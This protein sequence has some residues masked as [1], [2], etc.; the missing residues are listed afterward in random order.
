MYLKK[1][2]AV[3]P[4]AE[5]G[6]P[7]LFDYRPED[8]G[9]DAPDQVRV[10]EHH[11]IT[12]DPGQAPIR[13]DIFLAE[14]LK[15]VTRSRIKSAALAGFIRVNNEA[16]KSSYKVRPKDEVSI[17]LPFPP[18]I[19]LVPENIPLDI[20]HEDEHLMLIH[21]PAGMVCHPGAGNYRG[22]LINALLGYVERLPIPN[23][24]K[25]LLRPGLVHR[26]DKETSG[27]LLIAK[28][29]A[30]FNYLA[31]QFLERTTE[32]RYIALVW[33]DVQADKGTV[34]AN[35]ARDGSDRF[36]FRVYE[37]DTG[38]H[39]VTHYEVLQRFGVFT[40][41]RC[42]LETGRTHQI[43]VHMKYLG[44]TLFCDKLYGGNKLLR[45]KP[46]RAFQR[47]IHECF[48]RMPRHALHAKTLGFNHPADGKFLHFDSDLPDDFANLLR[49]LCL[50]FNVPPLP[51]LLGTD[52]LEALKELPS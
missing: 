37:D 15:K 3:L 2:R 24:E 32:R 41:V 1:A 14:R 33:G 45:G 48:E 34:D 20:R 39:A 38:R 23:D 18:S 42:K 51:E 47:F 35:I 52:E 29:E 28:S 7:E 44:H 22:T 16:V 27:L 25:N 49:R 46:S 19:T 26:I 9:L 8:Y 12:A 31:K 36:R 13:V 11:C 17:A 43:R 10:Y 40:L 50:F 5:N 21:K 30:A 4:A 6:P